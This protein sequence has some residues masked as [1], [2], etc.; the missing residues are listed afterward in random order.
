MRMPDPLA[1]AHHHRRGRRWPR[2]SEAHDGCFVGN[3]LACGA[4]RTRDRAEQRV[5]LPLLAGV[6]LACLVA[7]YHF[8]GGFVARQ[9][10]LDPRARTPAERHA[11]GVDFVPTAPFYLLGQHFSAIAAAG[12]IAGPILACQQFGWLPSILGS[13][14]ACLVGA[15]HDFHAGGERAARGPVDRGGDPPEPRPARLAGDA[16]VHL[17]GA[18]LRD[19]RLRR[20]HGGDLRHRRSGTA[21][22]RPRRAASSR[23]IPSWT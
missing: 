7:G 5:C 1:P 14:S 13:P 2:W 8:Y 9:Y 12:P 18:R 3:S 17:G 19:R 4:H 15:V 16:G 6:V 20:H 22:R 23:A 11:D 21:A 10:A